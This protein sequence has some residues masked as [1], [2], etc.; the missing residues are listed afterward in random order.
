MACVLST[1]DNGNKKTI[2]PFGF[3]KNQAG[4][5]YIGVYLDATKAIIQHFKKE[6]IEMGI[7]KERIEKLE[8]IE[9]NT[10]QKISTSKPNALKQSPQSF[11]RSKED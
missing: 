5:N 11:Q 2:V 7:S 9:E 4:N 6:L 10:P 8:N 3:F 1:I